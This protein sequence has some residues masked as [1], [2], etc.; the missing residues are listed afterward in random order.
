M[1]VHTTDTYHWSMCVCVCVRVC[2]CVCVCVCLS[3]CVLCV[4]PGVGGAAVFS[5]RM[6]CDGIECTHNC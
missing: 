3:V 5:V 6:V 1:R 2:T 4:H